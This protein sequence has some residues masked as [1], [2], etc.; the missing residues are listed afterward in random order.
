MSSLHLVFCLPLLITETSNMIIFVTQNN[1]STPMPF[2]FFRIRVDTFRVLIYFYSGVW[3]FFQTNMKQLVSPALPHPQWSAIR[4]DK[5]NWV[6]PVH[7]SQKYMRDICAW[8]RFYP[9]IQSWR[10]LAT[11]VIY[12]RYWSNKPPPSS[13]RLRRAGATSRLTRSD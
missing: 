5:W 6:S 7:L 3:N 2:R 4:E 8:N 13:T 10:I 1:I 12:F 9:Q 11:A